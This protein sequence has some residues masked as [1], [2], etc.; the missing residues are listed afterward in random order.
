M[1][2]LTEL[3]QQTL[4][5]SS[6]EIAELTG[7]NHKHVMADVRNMLDELGIQSAEFSA[8][9]RDARGRKQ[10]VFSLPKDLT[11]TLAATAEPTSARNWSMPTRCG[12]VPSSIFR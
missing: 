2:A 9:Y 11:L 1:N 12:S 6:R 5:M 10:P 4:T 8:D 3:H 7:K